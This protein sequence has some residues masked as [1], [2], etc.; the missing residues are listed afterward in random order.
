M[1]GIYSFY[2]AHG[3][4]YV[5]QASCIYSRV[6]SHKDRFRSYTRFT[7]YDCAEHLEGMDLKNARAFLNLIEAYC[8]FHFAPT[9]NLTRPDFFHKMIRAGGTRAAFDKAAEITQC[10]PIVESLATIHD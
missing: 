8:I 3:C 10:F 2:D 1:V 4:I 5:G 6:K 7:A 9:Q